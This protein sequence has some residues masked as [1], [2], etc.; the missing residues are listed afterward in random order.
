L[1]TLELCSF[2]NVFF[3]WK[4]YGNDC[5]FLPDSEQKPEK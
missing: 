3:L 2:V 5:F 1:I 4:C